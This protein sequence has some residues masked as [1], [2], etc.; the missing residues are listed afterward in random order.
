LS[1]FYWSHRIFHIPF[2]YEKYHK[3]HH[4]HVNPIPWTALYV[5]PGEFIMAFFGIFFLPVAVLPPLWFGTVMIFWS[6]IMYSLVSSHSN[7]NDHHDLHHQTLKGHYGSRL[8][9]WDKINSE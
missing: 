2:F 6:I 3:F 7:E 4:A 8:G 9:I 5:H 1:A